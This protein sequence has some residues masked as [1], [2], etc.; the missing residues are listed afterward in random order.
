MLERISGVEAGT[1]MGSMEG[2]EQ[3]ASGFEKDEQLA[4]G[5]VTGKSSV[6]C[7]FK[8]CKMQI[9]LWYISSRI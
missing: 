7:S 3:R 5:I 2:S 1:D 6:L 8:M 9:S 4:L